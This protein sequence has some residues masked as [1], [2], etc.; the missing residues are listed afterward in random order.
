MVRLPHHP[1]AVQ[2]LRSPTEEDPWRVLMSGCLAGQSCGVNAT[3]YGLGEHRPQ[4][5]SHSKVRCFSFCPEDYEMGTPRTMPDLHGGDGFAVLDG[6]AKV[7][8]ENRVDLTE[9]MLAGANAML[10]VARDARVDFA[11]L[12][13]R[14]GACGSQVI[15]IGCR[16]EEPVQHQR[17]VGVAAALLLREGIPVVSQRDYRTLGLLGARVD[18]AFVPD[19][20][21]LDHHESKW[22]LENLPL[23][24]GSKEQ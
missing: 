19:A 24:E 1:E 3:D 2:A 17:G 15:S 20:D 5:L 6:T 11:V 23:P 7:L 9:A 12:T 22:V 16:F 4:W 21:G 8:D 13:D 10:E 18:S 14:S